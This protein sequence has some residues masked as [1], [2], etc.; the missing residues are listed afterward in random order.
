MV[1]RAASTCLATLGTALAGGAL[2]PPGKAATGG[3]G[4]SGG[5]G[6]GGGGSGGGGTGTGTGTLLHV[7]TGDI[8]DAVV[9]PPIPPAIVVSASSLEAGGSAVGAL[10]PLL[11]SFASDEQDGVRILAVDNAVALARLCNGGLGSV[12]E[13]GDAAAAARLAANARQRE[14]VVGIVLALAADRS[15]RVRW[16][17]ANRFAEVAESAGRALTASQLL[18]P[19]ERLLSDGEAEVRT[20]AA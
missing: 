13:E 16:S 19:F 6:G 3:E 17:V 8:T 20:T 4:S 5:S 7:E 9:P 12:T 11:A 14:A 1:R 10:F 18:A 15:W 2:P